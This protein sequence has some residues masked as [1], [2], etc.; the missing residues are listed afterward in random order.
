[1]NRKNLLSVVLLLVSGLSLAE[2]SW[3]LDREDKSIY[4]CDGVWTTEPCIS[5][6]SKL[7][8]KKFDKEG[9]EKERVERS[10][11][12]RELYM[13]Q[14]SQPYVE[15]KT[16]PILLQEF[17]KFEYSPPRRRT[18]PYIL[19][20]ATITLRN[21]GDVVT[22]GVKVV[23]ITPRGQRLVAGGTGTIGPDKSWDYIVEINEAVINRRA[24]R[25]IVSCSNCTNM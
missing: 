4:L 14:R 1:V 25:I 5:P 17:P 18:D 6:D 7:P 10:A 3:V 8:Y 11:L 21:I 19:K 16:G 13:R 20:S 9:Y 22:R 12:M 23:V 24:P 2:E 15:R